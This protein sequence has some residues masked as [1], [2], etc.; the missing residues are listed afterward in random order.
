MRDPNQHPMTLYADNVL[1][2]V[3]SRVLA[4]SRNQFPMI[5][6]EIRVSGAVDRAIRVF[7]LVYTFVIMRGKRM[8]GVDMCWIYIIK[9]QCM[10]YFQK[11]KSITQISIRYSRS[12][13]GKFF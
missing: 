12:T 4:T 9:L 2:V 1:N 7:D 6:D 10:K 11:K 13:I 8:K 3:Q 5:L